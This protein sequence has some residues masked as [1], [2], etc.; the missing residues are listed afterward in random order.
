MP[1]EYKN[2]QLWQ[3]QKE[4]G[5]GKRNMFEDINHKKRFCGVTHLIVTLSHVFVLIAIKSDMTYIR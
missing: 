5:H 4:D 3:D 1:C 2:S